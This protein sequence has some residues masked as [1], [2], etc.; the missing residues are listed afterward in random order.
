M[1]QPLG[2][3]VIEFLTK[4][5]DAMFSY[6]YT[7]NMEEDLAAAKSDE[8]RERASESLAHLKLLRASV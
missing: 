6:D 4:Y 8:D 5:F 3:V 2:I 7:K 1:I